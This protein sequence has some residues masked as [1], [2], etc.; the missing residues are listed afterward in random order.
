MLR[1]WRIVAI[2]TSNTIS[3]SL[4]SALHTDL[5]AVTHSFTAFLYLFS[6]THSSLLQFILPPLIF[7]CLPFYIQ[8]LLSVAS[9]LYLQRT[10]Y[11]RR[12]AS[13]WA[14]V[15]GVAVSSPAV[16]VL[17]PSLCSSLAGLALRSSARHCRPCWALEMAG[18]GI[19]GFW[20]GWIGW[21]GCWLSWLKWE[22]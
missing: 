10:S 5:F 2:S 1:K 7:L 20:L 13:D 16:F 19:W 4:L 12:P 9:P 15:Q 21:G 11:S 22:E 8:L 6:F 18:C 14:P 17:S 3:S